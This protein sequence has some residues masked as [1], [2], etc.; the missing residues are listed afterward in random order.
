MEELREIFGGEA[1]H[2]VCLGSAMIPPLLKRLFHYHFW[3][4]VG[5]REENEGHLK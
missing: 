1:D 4:E 3:N 5:L 2:T